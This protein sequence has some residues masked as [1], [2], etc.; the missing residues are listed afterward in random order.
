[1]TYENRRNF[2][3]AVWRARRAGTIREYVKHSYG[4][5]RMCS[6]SDGTFL[7]YKGPG[8]LVDPCEREDGYDPRDEAYERAAARDRNDD[9]SRT[10]GRDWT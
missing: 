8:A 1:M 4:Y 10:G 2:G 7:L 5:A 9:F 6:L 3:Q